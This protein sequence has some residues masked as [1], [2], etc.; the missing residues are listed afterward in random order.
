LE[1]IKFGFWATPSR[2]LKKKIYFKCLAISTIF[3]IMQMNEEPNFWYRGSATALR[4]RR[5]HIQIEPWPSHQE[6]ILSYSEPIME[7]LEMNITNQTE[8][9]QIQQSS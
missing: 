8:A 9:K 3:L 7:K 5:T 1:L 4:G 2:E 6:S